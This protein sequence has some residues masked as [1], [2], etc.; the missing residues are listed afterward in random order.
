M[1][2]IYSEDQIDKI[3]EKILST[4]TSKTL[5]FYG[6][7]GAG[8]TTLIKAMVNALGGGQQGNSPTFSIVNEYSSKEGKLLGYHFDFYRLEDEV[9]ALDLGL[10]DYLSQ[11]AWVFM[12]WPEKITSFLPADAEVILIDIIDVETRKIILNPKAE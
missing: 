12:E 6:S 2:I 4:V 10:E 8:K 9:E 1:V 11:D 7:M 3:A 5:L